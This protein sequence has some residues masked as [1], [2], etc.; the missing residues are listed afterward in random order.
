MSRD[1]HV[2]RI[3]H[4][5]SGRNPCR[6]PLIPSGASS[7]FRNPLKSGTHRN[8]P[9]F[10]LMLIPPQQS[11]SVHRVAW[12]CQGPP[13]LLSCR[14]TLRSRS[15]LD[16]G[17]S[18]SRLFPST[19]RRSQRACSD[20]EHLGALVAARGRVAGAK[21]T[22]IRILLQQCHQ[23]YDRRHQYTRS[24]DDCGHDQ[25]V[26]REVGHEDGHVY[27]GEFIDVGCA[28]DLIR[29]S[30]WTRL[31]HVASRPRHDPQ[32]G[33]GRC[34]Q[35]S[36]TERGGH[37]AMVG[38]LFRLG[39]HGHSR[40][41]ASKGSSLCHPPSHPLAHP[42]L[43]LPVYPSPGERVWSQRLVRVPDGDA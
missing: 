26:S 4:V 22:G 38:P 3:A 28:L 13:H 27:E 25:S 9:P 10:A 17:H 19:R 39:W 30:A 7:W 11:A 33:R 35:P 36:P 42:Q 21:G 41:L 24:Q 18:P 5:S 29:L 23:H 16:H 2:G 40:L 37:S 12:T 15:K 1:E 34:C 31:D 20:L 43:A 8:I 14:S 6:Q 32:A